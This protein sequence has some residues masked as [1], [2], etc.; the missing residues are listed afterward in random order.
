MTASELIEKLSALD[1]NMRMLVKHSN[2]RFFDLNHFESLEIIV[3]EKHN[4]SYY[5]GHEEY[6]D[7]LARHEDEEATPAVFVTG[8]PPF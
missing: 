2:G 5:G 6:R 1:P 8:F 7:T 4:I 3:E